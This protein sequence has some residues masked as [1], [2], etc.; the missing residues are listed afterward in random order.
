MT[1]SSVLRASLR[2]RSS[3]I[4]FARTHRAKKRAKDRAQIFQSTR[5]S[6]AH[7]LRGRCARA[8]CKNER[9]QYERVRPQMKN[10]PSAQSKNSLTLSRNFTNQLR[11]PSD[12]ISHTLSTKF[13]DPQLRMER[14]DYLWR[15]KNLLLK[16]L[17]LKSLLPKSWPR[18]SQPRRKLLLLRRSLLLRRLLLRRRNNG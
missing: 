11:N 12:E 5:M 13:S 2:R 17:L 16:S 6:D 15:S 18:R 4:F 10:F 14:G 8:R 1:S 9:A 3:K 7:K